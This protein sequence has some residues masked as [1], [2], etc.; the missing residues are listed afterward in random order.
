MEQ[1]SSIQ[2]AL[3][4]TMDTLQTLP[5]LL[6]NS[7]H[8]TTDCGY[9]SRGISFTKDDF[10]S[11]RPW[12]REWN[13]S[14]LDSDL[15]RPEQDTKN[16]FETNIFVAT[17]VEKP[18]WT[19]NLFRSIFDFYG[20]DHYLIQ[21]FVDRKVIWDVKVVLGLLTKMVHD[22][23]FDP[24]GL[25][26]QYPTSWFPVYTIDPRSVILDNAESVRNAIGWMSVS[27]SWEKHLGVNIWE[28]RTL[29]TFNDFLNHQRGV[30]DTVYGPQS[31]FFF[32][33]SPLPRERP[34]YYYMYNPARYGT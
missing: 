15:S 23:E 11:A 9:S 16:T 31:R 22:P 6:P 17:V 19:V 14:K 13:Q 12:I 3:N 5:E 1:F 21:A 26:T 18:Y 32:R 28:H 29:Y 7:L 30:G 2:P 24:L 4:K 20:P 8:T 10:D 33:N 34:S 27:K 25:S